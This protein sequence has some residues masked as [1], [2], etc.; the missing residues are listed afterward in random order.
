[1]AWYVGGWERT[2]SH[3]HDRRGC[4]QCRSVSGTPQFGPRCEGPIP[5]SLTREAFLIQSEA[6]C[7]RT[8]MT[9][10]PRSPIGF[11]C[12]FSSSSR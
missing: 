2:W 6:G 10:W 12:L 7:L 4:R 9:I 3:I 11:K 5:D 8:I 1:M